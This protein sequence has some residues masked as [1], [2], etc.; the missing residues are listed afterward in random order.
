MK[1]I[2]D[3]YSD[4]FWFEWDL[5]KFSKEKWVEWAGEL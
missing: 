4:R 3:L 5:H 2:Y 1:R